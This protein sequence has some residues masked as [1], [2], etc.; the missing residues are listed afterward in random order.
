M[1]HA[2]R[3]LYDPRLAGTGSTVVGFFEMPFQ[4]I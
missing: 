3:F 1:K 4:S 2:A